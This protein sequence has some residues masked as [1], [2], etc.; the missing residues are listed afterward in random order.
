MASQRD[1]YGRFLVLGV[2]KEADFVFSSVEFQSNQHLGH[3]FFKNEEERLL[4]KNYKDSACR[5]F[6]ADIWAS[7]QTS[8]RQVEVQQQEQ[9]SDIHPH[10]QEENGL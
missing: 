3:S 8:V 7:K 5:E 6:L 2:G 10:F 9:A 1:T 4:K